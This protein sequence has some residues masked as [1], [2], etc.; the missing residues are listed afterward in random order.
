MPASPGAMR[1]LAVAVGINQVDSMRTIADISRSLTRPSICPTL[2][3][4]ATSGEAPQAGRV[5]AARA[6][7]ERPEES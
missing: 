7:A 5:E 1:A 2:T 3:G 4:T 6:A